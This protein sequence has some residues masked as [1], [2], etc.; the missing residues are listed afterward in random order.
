M[1]FTWGS[2]SGLLETAQSLS[3]TPQASGQH[4]HF[5]PT[6]LLWSEPTVCVQRK[7][8]PLQSFSVKSLRVSSLI[9]T[10]GK[11]GSPV[12]TLT[13]ICYCIGNSAIDIWNF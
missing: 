7:Q 6:G 2:P 5:P 10:S 3:I 13:L 11:A 8:G 1:T 4:P 9:G 12:L